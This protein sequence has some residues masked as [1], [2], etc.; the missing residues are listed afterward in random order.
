MIFG[1][2]AGTWLLAVAAFAGPLATVLLGYQYA[3]D[4]RAYDRVIRVATSV[5]TLALASAL[6]YLTVQFVTGDYTNAYVWDNTANYLPLLY[7]LTGVYASNKGSVLLWALLTA[8]VATTTVLLNRFDVRGAR[9]TQALAMGVV[10][11]FATMLVSDSPFV[12]LAAEFPDIAA[13][14][15]P[16]DGSGLNPLLVDPFMAIHP[17]ITFSA[18]ALLVVPFALGVTHFVSRLRGHDSVFVEWIDS[19]TRWLRASWLLLT[20]AITLGGIWAY[21][22]LGWGGFWSWDP[23]ETAVLIPWLGLSAVL[24]SLNRYRTTGQ[25]SVL[26]PAATAILFPLVVFATTVVRSGVFRSVHSFAGGGIG[27][28]ILFI[29]GSTT[30]LAVVPAFVYW[31]RLQDAAEGATADGGPRFGQPTILHA[32]VLAFVLLAF[33]SVWGLSFPVI[34]NLASGVEVGVDAR[35][36]NLWSFPVV[37]FMLLGG[38]AYA[39]RE[40]MSGRTVLGTVAAVLV[41]TL[42]VGIGLARPE[43]QLAT[44]E[45]FDPLYYRV[46]GGLS[47][48]TVVPP[49]AYF[50]AGWTGRFVDRVARIDSRRVRLKETGVVLIHVGAAI[51]VV[52][53]SLV[54]VFSATGS[55]GIAGATGLDDSGEPVVRAVEGTPYTVEVSDY[56]PANTP[57]VTEAALSP[58]EVLSTD[59]SA[60][61]VLVRGEVTE[62][63]RFENVT[64]AQLDGSSVWVGADRGT[65]AFEPGT[66]VVVR[67]SLSDPRSTNIDA[68]VYTDRENAGTVDDP[69]TDVYQPRVVDHRFQVTLYRGEEVVADGIVAEQSYRGRDMNTNDPLIARGPL[70]DTYVVGTMTRG[71]GLS[72]EVSRYPLANQMWFGVLTMLVGM[73]LLFVF[74]PAAGARD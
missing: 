46:V 40:R 68:L 73:C 63:Q 61:A 17:P 7:K 65:V 56:R 39:Q 8:V 67:G 57:T 44:T 20:A 45:P 47:V 36:Y 28:G 34:R 66:E 48:L 4:T 15:V 19:T 29:L 5:T 59:P 37:V 18:Y 10:S 31:F 14:G 49:A 41:V 11:V 52:A 35:Y 33:V 26:A 2:T 24:H 62:V 69:P 25:Y 1:T 6:V 30:A 38:G 22:V 27:S 50:A 9:L 74:D 58:A 12:P 42:A 72:I 51:L 70:G 21:R 13:N 55:V 53:V 71:G 23:V 3:A 60:T 43:W 64:I 16:A 54:Y 32:A